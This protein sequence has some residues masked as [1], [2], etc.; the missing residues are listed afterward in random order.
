MKKIAAATALVAALALVGCSGSGVQLDREVEVGGMTLSVPSD[1]VEN[2]YD[3]SSD[4]LDAEYGSR[5]FVQNPDEIESI[6]IA[7]SYSSI[8]LDETPEESFKSTYGDD[9]EYELADE[10]VIDG[11]KTYVYAF[12]YTSPVS[13][14][15][16]VRYEAYLYQYDMHYEIAVYG[17]AVSIDDVLETVDLD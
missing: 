17:D 1:W 15:D 16:K 6:G 7:V 10:M 9:V 3:D 11:V 4:Y 14:E 8:S 2:G 12:P 13:G 5:T